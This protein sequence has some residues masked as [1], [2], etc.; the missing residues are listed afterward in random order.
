MAF[1]RKCYCCG[2]AETSDTHFY[3]YSCVKEL[4][5]MFIK[6]RAVF[7]SKHYEILDNPL[8]SD[9]CVSCG[10]HTNRRIIDVWH[11]CEKCISNEL[12][13]YMFGR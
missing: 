11:I 2:E 6:N 7:G 3:C 8:Y 5:E 1:G 13:E 12:A 9:H 10:E 4:N